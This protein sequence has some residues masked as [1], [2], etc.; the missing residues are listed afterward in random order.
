MCD[1]Q[2][3]GS[4]IENMKRLTNQTILAL[5]GQSKR[6][7]VPDEGGVPGLSIRVG[8]SGRKTWNFR[9]RTHLGKQR[10]ISLGQFGNKVVQPLIYV[11][12]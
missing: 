8:S 12:V 2:R 9:Y 11:P 4:Q 7:D 1:P 5:K 10:R 6:Y 3:L